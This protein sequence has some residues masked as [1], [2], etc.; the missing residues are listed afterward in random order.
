MPS[1]KPTVTCT[2]CSYNSTNRS[3]M[4]RHIKTMHRRNEQGDKKQEEEENCYCDQCSYHASS[5][6]DLIRHRNT[7]HKHEAADPSEFRCD[8]CSYTTS[9]T[10][11]MASHL[12]YHCSGT[13]TSQ[14]KSFSHKDE[15]ELH[16][17]FFHKP[18]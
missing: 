12:K 7:M 3:D 18:Q 17:S 1:N 14:Q 4:T 2:Q 9:S 15:L 8:K 13:C 5:R 11:A 6:N 10:S 16:I